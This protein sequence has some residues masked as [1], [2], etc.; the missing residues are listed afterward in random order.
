MMPGTRPFLACI[1]VLVGILAACTNDPYCPEGLSWCWAQCVDLTSEMNNCGRCDNACE[2]GWGCVGGICKDPCEKI[3]CSGH[4]ECEV[5]N[6]VP[7]CVCE[8]NYY[9]VGLAC[10]HDDPGREEKNG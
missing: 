8:T 3:F 7:V 10:V 4:G 1:L 5:Q 2:T 6:G 9:P